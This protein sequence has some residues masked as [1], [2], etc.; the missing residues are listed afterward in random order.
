MKRTKIIPLNQESTFDI[1]EMFFSRTDRKGVIQF[2]NSVFARVSG[3]DLSD[4]VGKPHNLI[5]HP[6]M[7]RAVFKLL[8]DTIKA[9][10]PIAAYVKNLSS[11]GRYYWVL[12]LVNPSDD[13]F[14]SVRIKPTSDLFIAVQDTYKKVLDYERTHS[15]DES[16]TFLLSCLKEAGFPSY[17]EFEIEALFADIKARWKQ[18]PNR[19]PE[20]LSKSSFDIDP[21]SDKGVFQRILEVCNTSSIHYSRVFDT[22]SNLTSSSKSLATLNQDILGKCEKLGLMV[23]NMAI[24][25]DKIGQTARTL[26]D[27]AIGFERYSAEIQSCVSALNDCM[28]AA[29]VLTNDAQMAL[30]SS[31]LQI[32]VTGSYIQEVLEAESGLAHKIPPSAMRATHSFIE[33]CSANIHDANRLIGKLG[34]IATQLQSCAGDL[35]SAVVGLEVI[36]LSG[37]VESTR[38]PESA[39]FDQHVLEMKDFIT[40][41][42]SPVKLARHGVDAYVKQVNEIREAGWAIQ[43]G[44]TRVDVLWNQSKYATNMK[45]ETFRKAS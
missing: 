30:A 40:Q 15:I 36:R 35:E 12:A 6:D 14:V 44:F 3:Y 5:R 7:P 45:K 29:Q 43:R 34:E 17:E 1:S 4:M 39:S 18:T 41:I 10:R 20:T 21:A 2:G 42:T 31:C 28:S 24:T 38:I 9:G 23:V 11:S 8:W 27:V 13:H 22:V 25:A 16:T 32:E 19:R 33:T 37:S 26:A